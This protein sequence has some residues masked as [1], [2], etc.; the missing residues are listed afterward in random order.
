MKLIYGQGM[1]PQAQQDRPAFRWN[2]QP[3]QKNMEGPGDGDGNVG[4]D[5]AGE[6]TGGDGKPGDEPKGITQA[7]LDAAANDA[8]AQKKLAESLKK[9]LD[10]APAK[11]KKDFLGEIAK[12]LGMGPKEEVTVQSL[13]DAL[14]QRDADITAK[15]T[16]L[17]AR[18]AEIRRLKTKDLLRDIIDD[19]SARP[20][21]LHAVMGAGILDDIDLESKTYKADVKA[22]VEA[23]VTKNPEFKSK[24]RKGTDSKDTT[25]DEELP[26][27]GDDSDIEAVIQSRRKAMKFAS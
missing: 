3:M 22:A 5:K 23:Y 14:K 16:D 25:G 18:D 7:Q 2:T 6:G 12:A 13:S 15:D 1:I 4:D 27:T 9:Q 11:L 26:A 19:I 8:A 21:T 10:E 20:S 17:S 24:G